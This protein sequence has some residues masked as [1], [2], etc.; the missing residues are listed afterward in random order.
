MLLKAQGAL[1]D[2]QGHS[3]V[4]SDVSDADAASLEAGRADFA[5][6]LDDPLFSGLTGLARADLAY[7]YAFDF[8][9]P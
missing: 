1:V 7:V 4:P 3:Q 5:T 2:A 6:L 9:N 8:P